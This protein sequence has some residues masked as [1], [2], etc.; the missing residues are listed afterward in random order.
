M[1]IANYTFGQLEVDGHTYRS[2]VVITPGGVIDGWWRREGHTLHVEDLDEVLRARPQALVVGTGYHARMQMPPETRA[3]LEQ[4]GIQ[5][6]VSDTRSAIAEFNRLQKKYAR[7]VAALHL[8][9]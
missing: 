6:H 8:T 4:R 5:V 2:D 9:C 3:Y 1:D 7:V